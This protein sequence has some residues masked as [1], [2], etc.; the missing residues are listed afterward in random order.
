MGLIVA[1]R[2]AL[3]IIEGGVAAHICFV[4]TQQIR[5]HRGILLCGVRNINNILISRIVTVQHS[6]YLKQKAA[7]LMFNGN[8]IFALRAVLTCRL[9]IGDLCENILGEALIGHTVQLKADRDKAYI[10]NHSIV[11]FLGTRDFLCSCNILALHRAIHTQI[12]GRVRG[13]R[14]LIRG[15]CGITRRP[16]WFYGRIGR[17]RR[18]GL[19]TTS[20]RKQHNQHQ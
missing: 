15:V 6:C 1:Y 19:N 14:R 7:G 11:V 8:D 17:F 2:V 3:R 4:K 9:H 16:S 20:D 5:D 18:F 12:P 10:R 13:V